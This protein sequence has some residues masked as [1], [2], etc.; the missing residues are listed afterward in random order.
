MS[1]CLQFSQLILWEDKFPLSR[2]WIQVLRHFVLHTFATHYRTEISIFV[3][4]IITNND[5]NSF[6]IFLCLDVEHNNRPRNSSVYVSVLSNWSAALFALETISAAIDWFI[7]YRPWRTIKFSSHSGY[8]SVSC[9]F[10]D[11][12][13]SN[14]N[15]NLWSPTW[16]P[17]NELKFKRVLYHN[18]DKKSDLEQTSTWTDSVRRFLYL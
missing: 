4:K 3:V 10:H 11:L 8:F 12:V 7:P 1:T 5:Q 9:V 15:F 16:I 17:N 6:S 13:I 2:N 14:L 18:L